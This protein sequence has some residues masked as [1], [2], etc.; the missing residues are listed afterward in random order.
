LVNV[1]VI[2]LVPLAEAPPV[3]PPVT[4][5][6]NQVYVVPTGTIVVGAA[7]TIVC[8][9]VVPLHT[10]SLCA[11]IIGTG[12]TVTVNVNTSPA[13]PVGDNGVITYVAVCT[14]LVGLV[15]VPVI[16]LVPLADAPP[17]TPPVTVGVNQVYVVPSGIIVV[18]ALFVSVS[19][20][21]S[22][23]QIVSLC[24]GTTGVGL[25]VT[26]N[27]NTSPAHPVGDNGVIT[28]V[29]V[30][31]VFVGLIRVPVIILCAVADAPPIIPPVTVGDD[32]LYVVPSGTISLL[33]IPPPLTGVNTKLS[34]LHII[35]SFALITGIG[36]TVT[37]NV[38]TSPGQPVGDTG[39]IRYVAV[40]TVFVGLVSV[41]VITLTPLAD[42][43]PMIP[44][45]TVGADQLYVV[46][47]GTIVV[48]ALFTIVC[49]N[50]V[51]LH[52]VSLCAGITGIGL[53]VTV[54]VNTSPAQ[55]VG[56]NGVIT[57]VAVCT[58]LVGLVNVPVI[59]LVPLADAPP[60]TPPVT[61]GAD[62]L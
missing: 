60:V 17:V 27:A 61:V 47:T 8:I 36:S 13:H 16:I 14:V 62:Q 53:I 46:P 42:A 6:V 37:V 55:P 20:N 3:T 57:Y 48:G 9:N 56:D 23:L 39:V 21:E 59:I 35:S 54:N 5:G 41:P 44:P 4:V 22:P 19:V 34:L 7:F 18:G 15:N 38:N 58:V 25:T 2:I 52:A 51:P 24:E 10:V 43:P 40:C 50:V 31:T 32:Q 28:Y 26:V 33:L 1:P 45:V 29:A 11:G 12:L 30:C 49:I